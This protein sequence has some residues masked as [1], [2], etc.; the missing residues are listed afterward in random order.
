MEGHVYRRAYGYAP[1]TPHANTHCL[2][3]PSLPLFP[4]LH[5]L[6]CVAETGT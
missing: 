1:P 2:L 3:L 5:G 4:L 6:P